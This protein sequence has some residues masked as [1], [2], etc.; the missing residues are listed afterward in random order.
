MLEGFGPAV[1]EY[2]TLVP[3]TSD[4]EQSLVDV[5]LLAGQ[6]FH[7]FDIGD[8]YSVHA[9]ADQLFCPYTLVQKAFNWLTNSLEAR[10]PQS[11]S[12]LSAECEVGIQFNNGT[13]VN[14]FFEPAFTEG[15]EGQD[16]CG[17]HLNPRD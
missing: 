7:G 4:P 14:K 10:R 9:H 12:A 2:S 15:V 13:V 6:R 17:P 16:P 8:A 3:L 11:F 1:T 5:L